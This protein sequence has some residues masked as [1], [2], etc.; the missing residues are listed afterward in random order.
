MRSASRFTLVLLLI[1][2]VALPLVGCNRGQQA[3]YPTK[4]I[5][6]VV[7]SE[8]GSTTDL[9]GRT[10]SD[11]VMKKQLSSQPVSVVTKSGGS[12]AIA[13][14]YIAEKKGDPYSV[15]A[16]ATSLWI[17]MS[18]GSIAAK[19]ADFTPVA[20]LDTEAIVLMVKADSPYNSLDDLLKDAKSSP[21]KVSVG[22]ASIGSA[23][24]VLMFKI[25]KATGAQFNYVNFKTGSDA[26]AAVL[27]GNCD[28]VTV[29]PG[30]AREHMDAKKMKP[31]AAFSDKRM[32]L[33][34]EVPTAK[35]LGLNVTSKLY[36]G[37]I[38]P[39]DMPKEAVTYLEGLFKKV[40]DAPEWGEFVRK[41]GFTPEY[42][43]SADWGKTM[44]EHAKELDGLVGEL[45]LKK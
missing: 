14:Q 7:H 25:Q 22:F 35:E 39:K 24:H 1:G 19:P 40:T 15:L 33:V 20:L 11:I 2:A 45:G 9:I 17:S 18:R 13:V 28:T 44:L 6:Y 27:G 29:Q 10:V 34:P 12:G 31:L 41:S 4:P 36:R 16:T 42:M 43:N 21:K 32:E 23:D 30:E 8:P 5:E 26:I 38:G 3:N 37:L